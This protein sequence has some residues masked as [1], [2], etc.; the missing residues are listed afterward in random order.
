MAREDKERC[1]RRLQQRERERERWNVGLDQ[2]EHATSARQDKAARSLAGAV[3]DSNMGEVRAEK[4][5]WMTM[6]M[7]E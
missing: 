2:I 3:N 5:P 1:L 6:S 4:N 7:R